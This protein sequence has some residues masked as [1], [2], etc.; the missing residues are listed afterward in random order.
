MPTESGLPLFVTVL[1]NPAAETEDVRRCRSR[2]PLGDRDRRF[3][4][5]HRIRGPLRPPADPGTG[6]ARPPVRAVTANLLVTSR[7]DNQ[8]QATTRGLEVAAHWSPFPAWR[9]DGSYTAF[10]VIPTAGDGQSGSDRGDHRRERPAYPMAAAIGVGAGPA[11]DAQPRDLP[12]RAARAVRV[13]AY[14]RA[15]VTAEWRVTRRL[16]AM[17]VGQNLFAA[18]HPEFAAAG[19]FL[20]STQVPRSASLR[21]R[22]TSPMMSACRGRGRGVAAIALVATLSRRPGSAPTTRATASDIAVK[23]ALLYNFAKFAE[24]PALSSGAPILVCVV[25]DEG[26]PP[27]S[28]RRSADKISAAMRSK[29]PRPPDSAHLARSATSCSLPMPRPGDPP[30][31]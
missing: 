6:G 7:F 15:D 25:G 5:R 29:C 1:G 8:L 30:M 14:T 21:L 31:D 26:S 17:A 12:R 3:D 2:L 18:A 24:W 10:H 19:S 13:D 4:R 22:W 27:R 11:R 9:I 23:A 28:S 20:L 16:S